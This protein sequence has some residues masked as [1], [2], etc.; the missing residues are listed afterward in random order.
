MRFFSATLKNKCIWSS[1][2]IFVGDEQIGSVPTQE[3]RFMAWRKPP[4][5]GIQRSHTNCVRW[6]MRP[7]SPTHPCSSKKVWKVMCAFYCMLMTWSSANPTSLKSAKSSPNCRKHLR[8]TW[9]TFPT[10]SESKSSIPPMAY[11]CLNDTRCWICCSSLAWPIADRSQ[12][13]LTGI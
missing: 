5:L 8:W 6:G 12:H 9:G 4:V 2:Q 10:S 7:P 3:S 1:P 11:C 13:P